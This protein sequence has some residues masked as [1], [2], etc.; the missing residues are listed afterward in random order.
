M[1]ILDGLISNVVDNKANLNLGRGYLVPVYCSLLHCIG[2]ATASTHKPEAN[3]DEQAQ[4]QKM[5]NSLKHSV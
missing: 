2:S 3:V 1:D 5:F 4:D